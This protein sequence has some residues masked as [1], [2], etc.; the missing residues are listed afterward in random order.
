MGRGGGIQVANSSEA[1]FTACN[2]VRL[3]AFT[4]GGAANLNQG[5]FVAFHW[6][7]FTDCTA[8][9][10]GGIYAFG[11]DMAMV[12]TDS[13][14]TRCITISGSLAIICSCAC[15]ESQV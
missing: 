6:C 15:L 10:G 2:F 3:R 1:Y 14:F 9:R 8:L 7:H 11:S 4:D 12:V 5:N 13:T